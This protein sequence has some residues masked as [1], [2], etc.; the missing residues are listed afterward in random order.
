[1]NTRNRPPAVSCDDSVTDASRDDREPQAF[2]LIELLIVIAIIA[3]LAALAFPAISRTLETGRRA[4]CAGNLKTIAAGVLTF[5]AENNY[6]L[7]T[8]S[9]NTYMGVKVSWWQAAMQTTNLYNKKGPVAGPKC[10]YCPSQKLPMEN[11]GSGKVVD[12]PYDFCYGINGVLVGSGATGD[13]SPRI[14]RMPEPGKT[15]LLADGAG[16]DEGE[17]HGWIV[18][19]VNPNAKRQKLSKRHGDSVN[20]AWLD[21]HV[22]FTNSEALYANT[23]AWGRALIK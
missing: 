10:M 23:N 5:A 7:P 6:A 9:N 20:A 19:N 12:S 16:Y 22:S 21:G 8:I 2:T 18:S 13:P 17:S 3:V 11:M 1:M 4:T 15:L 14:I